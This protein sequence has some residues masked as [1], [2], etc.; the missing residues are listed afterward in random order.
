MTD[1]SGEPPLSRRERK[2]LETRR[3]IFQAAMTLMTERSFDDVTIEEI[4]ENADVANATFFLHFPTKASLIE[5]FSAS[6]AELIASQLK[7]FQGPAFEKLELLRSLLVA[8]SG[9]HRDLLVRI[10]SE[11][12]GASGAAGLHET[13]QGLVDL[14]C[15]VIRAGQHNGEFRKNFDARLVAL[16]IVSGWNAVLL[17]FADHKNFA[18]AK[19]QNRAVLDVALQGVLDS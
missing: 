3:R 17:D 12:S 13:R 19:R 7:D 11:F 18:R 6:Q 10:V 9:R 5:E 15:D 16:V 2:K 4:C 8:E 14:V 1:P